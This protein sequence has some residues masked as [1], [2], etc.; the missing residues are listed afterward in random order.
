V[1]SVGSG[2]QSSGFGGR[3]EPLPRRFDRAQAASSFGLSHESM[4]PIV[5]TAPMAMT[6]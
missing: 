1:Q 6:G 4:P 5:T 3:A 2:Y